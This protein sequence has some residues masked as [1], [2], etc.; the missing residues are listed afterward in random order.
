[1]KTK[2][3]F[4]ILIVSSTLR[5]YSGGAMSPVNVQEIELNSIETINI[6]YNS[7]EK[8]TVY[9]NG[10]KN[11]MIKEYMSRDNRDYYAKITN[12]G[13]VLTVESGRIRLHMAEG[14]I[15]A[16]TRSGGINCTANEYVENISL[17]TT[18]GG[19]SLALPEN[20]EF[21]LSARTGGALSTPFPE[22]LFRP[23]A[24]KHLAEGI[25]GEAPERRINLQTKYSEPIRIKWIE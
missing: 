16:K 7:W 1:M 25:I 14:T 23:A 18:S 24:D 13:D 8:V 10:D 4:A 20:L 9:N 6:L 21:N 22:K 15:T 17:E 2:M 5:V 11:F 12:L 19:I 3:F